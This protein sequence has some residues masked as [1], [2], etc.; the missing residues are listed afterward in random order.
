ML[1]CGQMV[2]AQALLFLHLGRDWQWNVN[3]KE[4]A[5]LKILKMFEDRRTAPYSIHQIALTGASE[6]KAVGEWFGPNTVA[7]VLR[8][9]AKYDDWSSIVFHVALD[10]TLVVNQVKKLCTTNKRASSNPQWQP[11]VLVIPLRLGIQDINPVYIN[12]IKKC[13]AL[14]ISPAEDEGLISNFPPLTK[15]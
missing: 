5:Y 11:L 9:L 7:Q 14:P 13:Y 4:E 10:N 1:R 2:I 6:G 12:G 15:I 8:K 3:S